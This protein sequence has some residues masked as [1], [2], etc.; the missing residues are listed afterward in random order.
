MAGDSGVFGTAFSEGINLKTLVIVSHPDIEKSNTQQFLKASAATLSQVAWHHLDVNLPFDV[1][2]E[3]H[4]IQAADRIVF[5]FPLY[6]YMA[7]A[8]L[9][10]WLTEVWL[11]QFV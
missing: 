11:K 8:S 2:A 3:Q 10:Q 1:P 5:Q 9:H 4:A 6:W 7:P